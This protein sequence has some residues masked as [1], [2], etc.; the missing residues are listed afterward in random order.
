LARTAGAFE[1]FY[2]RPLP[3]VFVFFGGTTGLGLLGTRLM[4]DF[5]GLDTSPPSKG[6]GAFLTCVGFSRDDI[7]EEIWSFLGGCNLDT[8]MLSHPAND[9]RT[10]N[11]LIEESLKWKDY[12]LKSWDRVLFSIL[13]ER[14][15]PTLLKTPLAGTI[16]QLL[17]Q[18]DSQIW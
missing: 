1:F 6:S 10:D 9:F 3:L 16:L 4:L 8:L 18:S 17:L 5:T 14:Q 15:Y 12:W 7:W 11:M 13:L 2:A